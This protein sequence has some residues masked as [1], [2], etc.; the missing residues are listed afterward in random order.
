MTICPC[1]VNFLAFPIKFINTFVNFTSSV[2]TNNFSRGPSFTNS[3]PC[4]IFKRPISN[5]EWTKKCKS[6]T[7]RNTL[8]IPASKRDKSSTSSSNPNK[9]RLL[10]V[11]ISLLNFLSSSGNPS[12][13]IKLAKPTILFK[14]VRISCEIFATKADFNRSDSSALRIAIAISSSTTL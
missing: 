10:L 6:Q 1:V 7:R 12:S 8:S 5:I 2:M 14:G 11:I 9:A 4:A 3:T 13:T